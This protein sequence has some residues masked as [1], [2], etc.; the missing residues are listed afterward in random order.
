MQRSIFQVPIVN[1]D[2]LYSYQPLSIDQA[3]AW[4]NEGED[5]LFR[6]P[7]LGSIVQTLTGRVLPHRPKERLF[8]HT[9]D[10]ALIVCLDFPEI[11]HTPPYQRGQIALRARPLSLADLHEYVRFGLLRKFAR[12]DP[13][14]QSIVQWD[15]AFRDRRWRYLAHEAVLTNYG[16]YHFGRI[17]VTDAVDW[18]TAGP[19][20][21][22]LRYDATRKALELF[23][24]DEVVLWDSSNWAGFSLAPGDQ[25]LIAFLHTPGEK[26]Y[27]SSHI[28]TSLPRRMCAHI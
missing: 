17:P 22:Q 28:P 26:L 11:R 9:G 2:G 15:A 12:L 23:V 27:P 16:L 1:R 4:L 8:L 5:A 14:V 6:L 10:E 21:S 24:D 18:L 7:L 13:Y 20:S 19:Y 25:A 3:R